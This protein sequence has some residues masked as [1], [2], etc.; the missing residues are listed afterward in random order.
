M[1]ALEANTIFTEELYQLNNPVLVIIPTRWNELKSD[2]IVLLSK[3]LGSVKLSL[4]G[5]TILTM[6]EIDFTII[7]TYNPKW[8][9]SFGSKVPENIK[10]Y[11]PESLIGYRIIQSDSFAALDDTKK[12]SLWGALKQ[13]FQG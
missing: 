8:I 1:K 2:H 13:E 11:S 3:I 5:V 6:P 4:E 7:S 10:P 9:L 12:K